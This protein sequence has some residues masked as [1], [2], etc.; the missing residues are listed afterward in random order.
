M[1]KNVG[2]KKIGFVGIN[3]DPES[4]ISQIN[5]EGMGF[6]NVIETAN[7]TAAFLKD[8]KKCDLVVA[9]THIGYTKGNDKTT[10]PEL[11]RASKDI[12]III[13]GHSHTLIDPENPSKYPCI[14]ENAEG[15]PCILYTS[16]SPRHRG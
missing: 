7:S 15:R 8:K 4:I 9:V 1:V 11:A 10:D 14:V 3:I 2:G 5:Y 6:S 12:D 13:G 16:P